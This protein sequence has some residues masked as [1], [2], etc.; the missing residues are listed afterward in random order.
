MQGKAKQALFRF[1]KKKKI[2]PMY[3]FPQ[4]RSSSTYPTASIVVAAS[5]HFPIA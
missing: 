5:V 3:G 1:R 4:I 2:K